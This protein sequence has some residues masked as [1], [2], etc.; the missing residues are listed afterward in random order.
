M[1][2]K[3]NGNLAT[4]SLLLVL[5]IVHGFVDM[6]KAYYQFGSDSYLAG[7]AEYRKVDGNIDEAIRH[8]KESCE[9]TDYTIPHFVHDYAHVFATPRRDNNHTDTEAAVTILER[10]IVA[11]MDLLEALYGRTTHYRTAM[12]THK[13]EARGLADHLI[14]VYDKVYTS[15]GTVDTSQRYIWH[16]LGLVVQVRA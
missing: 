8:L 16:G 6:K 12:S 2:H 9:R 7:T 14:E 4:W 11:Q 15:D 1:V 5:H 10:G 13:K 3:C